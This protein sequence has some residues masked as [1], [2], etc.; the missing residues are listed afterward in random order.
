MAASKTIA[1]IGDAGKI[2]PILMRK[3]AQENLRLLFVA[4]SDEKINQLSQ[5]LQDKALA[6]IEFI[7]CE[8]EGCW[9]AD[10][11]AFIEPE[12]IEDKLVN[13]IQAVATQKIILIISERRKAAFSLGEI[14]K[15]LPYS[16]IIEVE[17][18]SKLMEAKITGENEAA[19]STVSTIFKNA[20]YKIV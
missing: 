8:K 7:K 5:E 16:K 14:H 19:I 10:I 11:I 3:L 15:L 13:R 1:V 4:E 6:E 17:T 12:I 18:N 9:E 2:C 20:D